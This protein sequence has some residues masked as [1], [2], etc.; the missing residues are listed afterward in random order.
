MR[1]MRYSA[2]IAL[3]IAT[4]LTTPQYVISQEIAQVKGTKP[5]YVVILKDGR[6]IPSRMKPVNAFGKIRYQ[7]SNGAS[8][9]ISISKVDLANT[10]EAN[11]KVPVKRSGGTLSFGSASGDF[12]LPEK[13][14]KEEDKKARSIK[15]YSATWC[16]H[17]T[18]LKRFL[19]QKGL[20]AS[21]TEVDRLPDG[22]RQQAQA[23]MKRLTGRV[24]YPTV[25][26]GN[27]ARAGFSPQWILKAI[28]Q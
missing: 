23:E 27:Q 20:S 17:C 21:V 15:V 2:R 8:K 22:Q 10:R 26:I 5:P 6:R 16:P 18:S 19:A 13:E 7:D 11:A 1:M 24:A 3:M 28:E 12:N 25:V 9:L 14:K 4:G